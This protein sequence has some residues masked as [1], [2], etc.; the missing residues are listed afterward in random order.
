MNVRLAGASLVAL[1]LAGAWAS[2]ARAEKY[3]VDSIHSTVL[4]RILHMK[5]SY[6]WGRFDNV[7]GIVDLDEQDP[8][9]SVFDVVIQ[10]DS[11]DTGFPKRDEHLRG[12]D[13]FNARQ[14]PKIA[15]KSDSVRSTGPGAYEVQG[16]LTL[17][18]VTRPQSI[19]VGKVGS[20]KSPMGAEIIGVETSFVIKRSDFGMNQMLEGVGDEVLL[21]VSL[22]A[23]KK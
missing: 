23:A 12:P 22:E 18:G 6:T 17:H 5:T 15:F 3:D 16:K 2:P 8:A 14:F 11:V 20:G 7:T 4:F 1:V 10:T 21:I 19:K 9:K 13:F